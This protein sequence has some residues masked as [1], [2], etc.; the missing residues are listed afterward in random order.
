M[1][2]KSKKFIN[3]SNSNSNQ[4]PFYEIFNDPEKS[5]DSEKNL[6]SKSFNN[7]SKMSRINA[8]RFEGSKRYN[9]NES[10]ADA[11]L[12]KKDQEEYIIENPV[13]GCKNVLIIDD[14]PFNIIVTHKLIN[15]LDPTI[16]IT[17]ALDG[18]EAYKQVVNNIRDN[19]CDK[20]NFYT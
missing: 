15:N 16:K 14:E 20:C 7:I 17:K 1:P 4:Q 10:Y 18:I 19:T 6:M 5:Q 3:K 12:V 8:L 11:M 13:C 9:N 2:P